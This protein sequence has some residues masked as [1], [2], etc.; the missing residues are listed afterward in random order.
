MRLNRAH[1]RRRI[2]GSAAL[3]SACSGAGASIL[4][5]TDRPPA[6]ARGVAAKLGALSPLKVLAAASA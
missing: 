4:R 5:A 2:D 1:P 6:R 3:W